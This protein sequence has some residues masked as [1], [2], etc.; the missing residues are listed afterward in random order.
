MSPYSS[1]RSDRGQLLREHPRGKRG[2]YRGKI[3]SEGRSRRMPVATSSRNGAK[4]GRVS[5]RNP[6]RRV[7]NGIVE[8]ETGTDSDG[9]GDRNSAGAAE[10]SQPAHSRNHHRHRYANLLNPGADVAQCKSLGWLYLN[11]VAQLASRP[12]AAISPVLVRTPFGPPISRGGERS[13]G[14]ALRRQ[15]RWPQYDPADR[16]I[17]AV[18]THRQEE[19]TRRIQERRADVGEKPPAVVVV[20]RRLNR[21]VW[22]SAQ[23]SPLT[24]ISEYSMTFTPSVR[25]ENKRLA[26]LFSGKMRLD[27]AGS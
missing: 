3:S 19:L 14:R 24:K 1:S 12:K 26:R 27:L 21:I 8:V 7:R 10:R 22:R 17:N 13:A 2:P 23:S 20:L 11:R 16:G 15:N 4:G 6:T 25:T 9:G 18:P 5:R